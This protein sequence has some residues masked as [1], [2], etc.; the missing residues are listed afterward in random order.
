MSGELGVSQQQKPLRTI[1]ATF[2]W[3]LCKKK[4]KESQRDS[5]RAVPENVST[6]EGVD[7]YVLLECVC[8]VTENRLPAAV[9]DLVLQEKE[10]LLYVW[11]SL[12]NAV[13]E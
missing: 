11:S 1:S 4:K 7:W 13:N 3:M 12:D 5:P 9:Q 6:V 8:V 2:Y 10:K